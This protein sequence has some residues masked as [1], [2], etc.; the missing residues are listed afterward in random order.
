MLGV[1][2]KARGAEGAL[3]GRAL[4][5]HTR[6]VAGQ[7]TVGLV[8]VGPRVALSTNGRV[9]W[10][11]G[12]AV[13]GAWPAGKGS[14]II[15]EACDAR[16]AEAVG[17]ADRTDLDLSIDYFGSVGGALGVDKGLSGT[18]LFLLDFD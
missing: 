6:F 13:D 4:A 14:A 8:E 2:E 18:Y 17:T 3:A 10:L 15:G 5:G 11:A 16:R 7:A 1:E 12:S 9:V